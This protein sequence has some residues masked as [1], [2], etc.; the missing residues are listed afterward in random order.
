MYLI[1][2][3]LLLL[4]LFLLPAGKVFAHDHRSVNESLAA[5]V[6]YLPD[7]KTRSLKM[8]ARLKRQ[9]EKI[10]LKR[11]K[12]ILKMK[13]RRVR[14]KSKL[15]KIRLKR[16]KRMEKIKVRRNKVRARVASR[17][18]GLR[19]AQKKYGVKGGKKTG[20]LHRKTSRMSLKKR[21]RMSKR[22]RMARNRQ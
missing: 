10:K 14:D 16:K 17:V 15:S 19:S 4:I 6:S 18:R 9:R 3:I 20:K 13:R 12:Q 21:M 11:R 5:G 8:R 22:I 7:P 1:K 2:Y